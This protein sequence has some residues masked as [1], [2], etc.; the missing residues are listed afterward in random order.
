[1]LKY[2]MLSSSS[3]VSLTVRNE[4]DKETDTDSDGTDSDKQDIKNLTFDEYVDSDTVRVDGGDDKKT[5][6]YNDDEVNVE[7]EWVK[8]KS[9]LIIKKINK[10]KAEYSERYHKISALKRVE[11]TRELVESSRVESKITIKSIRFESS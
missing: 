1:M 3:S 6:D 4:S 7:A 9:R 5:S 2:Q 10:M 11:L 8:Q